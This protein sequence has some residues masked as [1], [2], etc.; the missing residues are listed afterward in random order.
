MI[1]SD[2]THSSRI[3]KY[4][5]MVNQNT[6]EI[7]IFKDG[8]LRVNGEERDVDFHSLGPSV[9][10]IIANHKSHLA[11][12]GEEN[13]PLIEIQLNGKLYAI[14]VLDERAL[15]ME[16]RR[17][18]QRPSSGEITSPM[19][20]VIAAVPVSLGQNVDEGDTL[21]VLESMKMQ[22]ELKSPLQGKVNAIRCVAGE[23]VDKGALLVIIDQAGD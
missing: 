17:G 5:T 7:E 23:T 16:Q 20:G 10:S 19:P 4:N 13:G 12:I 1:E 2:T 14:G 6:Y 9:Y 21:I 11:I 15:L 8:H 3:A 22:N 18:R